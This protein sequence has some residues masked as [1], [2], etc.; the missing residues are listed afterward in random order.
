MRK[1]R[2][3]EAGPFSPDQSANW[4]TRLGAQR[5][6][7]PKLSLMQP[8]SSLHCAQC[9]KPS[10][11]GREVPDKS[12]G[13]SRHFCSSIAILSLQRSPCCP[14]Q[15]CPFCTRARVLSSHR[16]CPFSGRCF[17]QSKHVAECTRAGPLPQLPM[18][19]CT[20]VCPGGSVPRL[21]VSPLLM[22]LRLSWWQ[23][24]WTAKESSKLRTPPTPGSLVVVLVS[25][26][27]QWAS[28]GPEV[29]SAL[30]NPRVARL[31][32]EPHH[33]PGAESVL[34]SPGALGPAAHGCHGVRGSMSSYAGGS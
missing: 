11:A 7:V 27:C 28:R 3:E 2:H 4:L 25:G 12:L 9:T 18:M 14:T 24:G 8:R 5:C 6:L 15:I 29:P 20:Q 32:C 30:A 31:S 33:W 34:P 1:L 22:T 19:D 17:Q 10:G 13:L 26:N 23:P 16:D 21:V